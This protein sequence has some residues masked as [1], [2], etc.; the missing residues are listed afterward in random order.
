MKSILI[1][2]FSALRRL[3]AADAG[4]CSGKNRKAVL[5]ESVD[6]DADTRLILKSTSIMLAVLD[7]D[8][9]F[10]YVSPSYERFLGY[11][12][13]ELIG[14][15]GLDLI[16][17]DDLDRLL[18]ILA[19]GVAG[20][21][22]DVKLITYRAI[23]KNGGIRY[24]RSSFDSFRDGQGNLEKIIAVGDDITERMAIESALAESE[25]RLR[26]IMDTV[27]LVISEIDC[28][29]RFQFV[30][31]AYARIFGYTS[32]DLKTMSIR[33]L[34]VSRREGDRLMAM[35]E[36]LAAEQP[37]PLPWEGRNRAK[38]GKILDV[39]V[40]WDYKR[41]ERGQVT[42]FI[43]AI[44]DV[45]EAKKTED[46]LRQSQQRYQAMFNNVPAGVAVYQPVDDGRDFVL[47]DFNNAA[48]QIEN[49]SREAIIGRKVSDVFP[50]VKSFGLFEVLQRVNETGRPEQHPVALYQDDRISS[51][52]KNF[53]YK[54]PSGEIVALY[55]DETDRVRIEEARRESD[56]RFRSLVE[57]SADHVF[58]INHE[59]EYLFSND[60]LN[61]N[62]FLGKEPLAGKPLEAAYPPELA[63]RF[64]RLVAHVFKHGNVTSFEHEIR[65]P[66]GLFVYLN[67]LY[68]IYKNGRTWAVGG[69]SRDITT[70]KRY[71]QE[72][73]QKTRELER[74]VEELRQTQRR[75]IDQ[76]RQ[77]ALSLMASGIAHDFNNSLTSI[78]GISD[79]L[80]QT[81][82]KMNNP[83]TVKD[84]ITL[85]NNAARDAA[86]IVRRLRKFYRPGDN[87]P[88]G[89]VDVNAL[90]EE[91]LALTEPVWRSKAQARG[92]FITI[93]KDLEDKAAIT[94]NRAEIHDVITNLIF[95]AVDAMPQGGTLRLLTRRDGEWLEIIVNDSG[96]GMDSNVRAQCLN[97]F[98]TTKGE[99]GS[100]L[101]LATVQG[102]I[103]RHGGEIRI[104]SAP[105]RGTTFVLRL[106]ASIHK[107][108]P[109]PARQSPGGTLPPLNILIVD[110]E[111]HQR[112]LLQK[113]LQ[114]DNHRIQ[115]ASNGEDGMRK[116]SEDRYD[117]V[118]TDLAMPN[119]SG[120]A[121]AR[122]I[123]RNAPD[124]PVIL[125]TGFGDMPDTIKENQDIVDLVITKPVTLARLREAI[126]QLIYEREG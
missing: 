103:T 71:E 56:A 86:Q 40:D 76:E 37:P 64:R 2:A 80:L 32:D 121:L 65:E 107:Q 22:D 72:L 93:E 9:C 111:E 52:R 4:S 62:D 75:I 50:G 55:I 57:Y 90:I 23:H 11:I 21:I 46:A 5:P 61:R 68:P 84:Y 3:F 69:I 115:T 67:T 74:T 99:A 106:P 1:K 95:N 26:A 104:E 119:L 24:I 53:V 125:L 89:S 82:E 47:I 105:G 34:A 123:K 51:W 96:I 77:R 73:Q 109:A 108:V 20:V 31:N 79:L 124:K 13:D 85:I 87:E 122:D 36:E 48:E 117:L 14:K 88:I 16:H 110:D 38:S 113:Y 33:D 43:T 66:G 91:A 35:L 49:I 29:G 27:P 81:P 126:S 15:S 12:P 118:I 120:T 116:F 97:P 100:G 39:V 83:K 6:K 18:A 112:L 101:G 8:V 7:R 92:A 59:G 41:D 28:A 78:Q 70:R 58:M 102:I 10:T 94:G 63:A 54:L 17:P 114:K 45:S 42:G 30:N 25:Q 98:F 60:R 44:S 19:K